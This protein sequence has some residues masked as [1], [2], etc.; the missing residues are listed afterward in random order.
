[1]EKYNGQIYSHPLNGGL[2]KY[3]VVFAKNC[4]SFGTFINSPFTE[5]WKSSEKLK[6]QSGKENEIGR[7][8]HKDAMKGAPYFKV[9]M[10]G[11]AKPIKQ[12]IQRHSYYVESLRKE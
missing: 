12:Q 8:L 3:H 11:K 10:E 5:L 9:M 2:C 4:E 1:M 7:E 6:L